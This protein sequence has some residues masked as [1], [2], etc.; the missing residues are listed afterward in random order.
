MLEQLIKHGP[1]EI[2]A[3]FAKVFELAMQIERERL[4]GA[5]L[6][7]RTLGSRAMPMATSPS[8]SIRPRG[9]YPCRCQN[10]RARWGALLPA[11][12]RAGEPLG[13]RCHAGSGRVYIKGVSTRQAEAVMREFGIECLSSAQ[14]SRAARLLDAEL[15]AWHNRP[16]GET[17]YL[18]LARH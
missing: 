17:K 6:Y 12:A 2:A 14:V 13:P 5:S 4:L 18:I 9:P 1:G 11:V 10:C 8:R 15:E 16:L 7:E 3:V